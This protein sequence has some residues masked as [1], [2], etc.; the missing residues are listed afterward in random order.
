MELEV[1]DLT[2]EFDSGGY[3][4]RPLDNL[5]MDAEDGELVVLLGPSGCG[6][7][8]LLSCLSGLLKPTNGSIR[9]QDIDVVG[10]SGAA[11]GAYR[12]NTVGVVFQAFN[13]LASLS[14]RQNVMVPMTL[15]GTGRREA[16]QRAN[17]LLERVSLG[18]RVS[19]RPGQMSGGQQQRVAIA[20]ALAH[21]PPLVV[22]DEPT[23]H[24]DHIQVEGILVLLRDLATPGRMVIVST[25]DD[26]ITHIADR[27]VELSPEAASAEREPEELTLGQWGAALLTGRQGRARLRGGRGSGRDLPSAQRRIRGGVGH[28]RPRQ[29]LRRDR[30]DAQPS[31]ERLRSCR[32]PHAAARSHRAHLPETF[33]PHT[34]GRAEDP[35]LSGGSCH[36]G[37]AAVPWEATRLTPPSM[38]G[39]DAPPMSPEIFDISISQ[40]DG[41]SVVRMSGELDLASSDRLT[42][43]L[44]ELSDQTVVVDLSEL[45]F[46]DSSGIAAL[47]AAKDRLRTAG[48]ELVLTRPQPN[49]D[50][51][52]EITGLEEWISQWRPEWS[53]PAG[54]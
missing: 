51:V 36:G 17:A 32:C 12:Q 34:E 30:T 38:A 24:L 14:A 49:V 20:R 46:I 47:V 9:F 13:L 7:T 44:A 28:D 37:G 23:A 22:A 3:R 16:A 40:H 11:L 35:C 8:T 43:L 31:P 45:T 27:V 53:P 21:D 39:L 2:V 5:K 48:R 42:E 1:R 26:R 19:H 15:A 18:E 4:V 54:G 52:L 33:S 10:L 6:K 29:L 41:L 50:R 25:H